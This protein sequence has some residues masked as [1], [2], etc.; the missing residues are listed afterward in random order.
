MET[1][2]PMPQ[3]AANTTIDGP[4][5]QCASMTGSAKVPPAAPT[6]LIAVAKPIPVART[7]VGKSSFG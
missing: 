4:T 5:P 7:S 6:R 1:S 3:M 2:S